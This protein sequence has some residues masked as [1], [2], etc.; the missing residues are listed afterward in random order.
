[1]IS[2]ICGYLV[3]CTLSYGGENRR[4]VIV[5]VFHNPDDSLQQHRAYHASLSRY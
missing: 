2:A 4:Y 5:S 3:S 1:M